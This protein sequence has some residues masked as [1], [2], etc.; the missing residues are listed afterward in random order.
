MK[1]HYNFDPL[2]TFLKKKYADAPFTVWHEAFPSST[3]QL[4]E[5]PFNFLILHEP[6]ELFGLHN[7]A[8]ANYNIFTA[9][10]TWSE[11]ILN[12]VPNGVLF[13]HDCRVLDND[14]LE[15]IKDRSKQFG[16]SFLSG[17]KDLIEGHQVRQIIYKIGDH[18][19]IPKKWFHT[20]EDFDHSIGVRPGYS[21][22]SKDLSHIPEGVD[23]IGFGKRILYE[24][25]MFNVVIESLNKRNWY[26]KIGDSFLSKCIP[27][28]W[29]CPNIADFGYDERGII[30]FKNENELIE[31]LNSLTPEVYEQMKPYIEY[32]CEVAKLDYIEDKAIQ[33]FDSFLQLNNIK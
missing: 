5:N 2:Y 21:E 29:G 8:I 9:I 20:L 14:F 28:Y 27:V 7:V 24:D 12:N 31:I 30:R 18:I 6:N 32:N 3:E 4:N 25:S 11:L 10:L 26:N 23:P 17:T 1:L 22:Y 15:S 13:T 33:F 19:Q 16:V